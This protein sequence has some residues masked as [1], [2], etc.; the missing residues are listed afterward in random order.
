MEDICRFSE[1]YTEIFVLHSNIC[2]NYFY[3]LED[4]SS[5][6]VCTISTK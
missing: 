6:F 3:A 4:N 5:N 2:E 1:N